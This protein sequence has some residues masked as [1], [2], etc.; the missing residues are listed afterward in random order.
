MKTRVSAD[1]A[2]IERVLQ[3]LIDNALRHTPAG[4]EVSLALEARDKL[5]EV[6]VSDTGNGI[7]FEH[8]PHIFERYWRFSGVDGARPSSTT[9]SGTG[10]EFGISSG[11]GLEIVKR[12]LD[13]HSSAVN[14]QSELTRGTR[15]QFGL[16]RAN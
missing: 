2:L 7:A 3:N 16:Q 13:L 4:G 6:S 1:I 15:I 5:I 9:D 14:V 11:L 10:E 8:L 12:I